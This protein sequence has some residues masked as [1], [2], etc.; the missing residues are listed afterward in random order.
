MRL[1]DVLLQQSQ[2]PLLGAL[3]NAMHRIHSSF[4]YLKYPDIKSQCPDRKRTKQQAFQRKGANRRHQSDTF[5]CRCQTNRRIQN[6]KAFKSPTRS[7]TSGMTDTEIFQD[8]QTMHCLDA[9]QLPVRNAGALSVLGLQEKYK[10]RNMGKR[11]TET[12]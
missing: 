2:N 7:S 1:R 11:R 8:G 6:I 12:E 5:P 9:L 10:Q 4:Q 3:Y